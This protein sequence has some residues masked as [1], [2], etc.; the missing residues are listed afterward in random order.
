[1]KLVHA[2][3]LLVSLVIVSNQAQA[4]DKVIYGDDN[5]LD[6]F[7]STN[8]LHVQLAR[9]T[10]AMIPGTSL[11]LQNG[12][13]QIAGPSMSSRG[14]C[15]QERFSNQST[16]AN[17]SGFLVGSKYIVT[18]GHC[19][20]SQMDCSSYKWVFDYK[21]E[22]A[23]QSLVSVETDS[24]YSCTRILATKLDNGG[25]QDDYALIE[26][27]R[28]VTDRDVLQFRTSGRPQVGDDIVVIG[29]PTGLPTKIADNAK[30][31]SL[32]GK[33]FVAN[34]DTYGGNSGSAVFNNTTG[35]IEGILVR[36]E[37]DYV[38]DNARGCR[39]SNY[40]SDTGCRGE[41]VTYITN[42][43]GLSQIR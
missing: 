33:F 42:V 13:V 19:I 43:P 34:L 37:N 20:R 17:C 5:R 23:T 11:R 24:V 40:C 29:H 38:Y 4:N 6:V 35:I 1:M 16:A 22:N 26:L 2:F 25:E 30:I 12:M 31:R 36:G 41:D 3:L 8:S 32:R 28:A 9:S 7:E 39:A 27:D 14:F 15:A 21:V 18:A 10:A